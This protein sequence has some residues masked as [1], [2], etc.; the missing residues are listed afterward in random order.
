PRASARRTGTAT[1][2]SHPRPCR[3]TMPGR[4]RGRCRGWPKA[5]CSFAVP[6]VP[7]ASSHPRRQGT[8]SRGG[9]PPPRPFPSLERIAQAHEHAPAL[10]LAPIETRLD[11]VVVAVLRLRRQVADVERGHEVLE[12]RVAQR[13]VQAAAA[14]DVHLRRL[15]EQ[16]I[17]PV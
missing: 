7:A 17:V 2:R 8:K 12:E 1:L 10:E 16:V 6:V 5:P 15:V 3:A 13:E 9:T 14:L 4:R 11:R